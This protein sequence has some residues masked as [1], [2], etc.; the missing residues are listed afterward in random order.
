MSN[1]ENLIVS[2][3]FSEEKFTRK[4]IPHLK[5]EYFEDINNKIIFEE[6]SKYFVEYDL[7]LIHI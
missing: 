6:T 2:S 1:L 5:G 7:S 3:L 4:V